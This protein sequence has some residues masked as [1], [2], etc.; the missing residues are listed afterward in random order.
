MSD[1]LYIGANGQIA[2]LTKSVRNKLS[3]FIKNKE[4]LQN[5]TNKKMTISV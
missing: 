4:G 3:Y 1:K 2:G 5:V